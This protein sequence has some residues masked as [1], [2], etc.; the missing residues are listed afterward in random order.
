M[1]HEIRVYWSFLCVL[2]SNVSN[3]GPT[4]QG[5]LITSLL[6][7]GTDPA[8]RL[9]GNVFPDNCRG[10]TY[11]LFHFEGTAEERNRIYATALAMSLAG[12]R[13]DVYANGDGGMC[14]IKN[15]QVT[16]GLNCNYNQM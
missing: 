10:G 15:I 14:R 9:T 12:K 1:N 5:G 13:V 4:W 3:S 7:S 2:F 16:S 11:G 6:A 8:I